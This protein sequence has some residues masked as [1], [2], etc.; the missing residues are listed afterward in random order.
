MKMKLSFST[1][2]CPDWDLSEVVAVAADLGY[3]GIEIRGVGEEIYAPRVRELLPEHAGELLEKLRAAKLTIPILTS[4]AYLA[5]NPDIAAAEA[6][7][8]D[9]VNLA[10]RL[11]VP[12][13]RVLG[14]GTPEPGGKVDKDDVIA[15]FKSLCEYAENFGVTLLVETN[16]WLAGSNHMLDFIKRVC[17]PNAGVL[18]DVHH[19]VRFFGERPAATVERLGRYIKHVHVKDSVQ[20]PDGKIMYVLTGYGDIPI[21]D[22]YKALSA[23][24]YEGFYSYEWVKRWAR[25]LDEPGVAFYKYI[26]YMRGIEGD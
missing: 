2:G 11:G 21:E 20:K 1:L 19:T 16:G 14:E 15:R 18:W 24:G 23:I 10:A 6:E 4:G 8:K 26:S 3:N 13:V 9:Y 5:N 22:A 25:E 17:M 7:V 12:Y